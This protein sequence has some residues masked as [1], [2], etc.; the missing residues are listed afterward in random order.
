MTP[1][2]GEPK[3]IHSWCQKGA[4]CFNMCAEALPIA[5]HGFVLHKGAFHYYYHSVFV[6]GISQQNMH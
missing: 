5:E 3:S 4:R 1:A 6:A 2:E